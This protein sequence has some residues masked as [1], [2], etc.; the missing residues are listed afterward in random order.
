MSPHIPHIV[1][2]EAD[3]SPNLR[4]SFPHTIEYHD[5]T[6]SSEIA[7]RIASAT[8]VVAST[9]PLT[10]SDLAAAPNLQCVS[11]AATGI[12]GFDRS[13]FARA[14]I[15]L[16]HCPQNNVASVGE[17]FLTLYFA[18]RRR[19]VSM[20]QAIVGPQRTWLDKG[21]LTQLWPQPPLGCSQETLVIVGYGAL[22]RRIEQLARGVGFG[23]IVIAE[24]KGAATVREGRM[25]FSEALEAATTVVVCCPK[26]AESMGLIGAEEIDLMGPECV[27]VNVGRGGIV[28]EAALAT[29]LREN[30]LAA[31]GVD[32]FETEPSGRGTTPLIPEEG[33][34]PPLSNRRKKNTQHYE[35]IPQPALAAAEASLRHEIGP[36]INTLLTRAEQQVERT[37]R[38]I[39]TL[40][41]R[42]ELQQGRL[43]GRDAAQREQE[44]EDKRRRRGKRLEGEARLRARVVRQKKEGLKYSVERLELEV[45]QKQRELR[46]RLEQ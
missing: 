7:A 36:S 2:L 13:M 14:G 26:T 31:A 12:D 38:R 28:D 40:K 6:P 45:L 1:V 18:S 25:A 41:A 3:N 22:G 5:F 17:H 46:K 15:T 23:R 27:L 34:V 4:F 8:I 43:S 37:A 9:I 44:R 29:A 42:A 20:H 16:T 30:R 24:H 21:I 19:T 10:A 39:E 32:V 33:E 11:I 35:L